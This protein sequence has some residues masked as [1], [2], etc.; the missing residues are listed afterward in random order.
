[1][2]LGRKI[3]A[4]LMT[5]IFVILTVLTVCQFMVPRREP[6]LTTI[7]RPKNV[8]TN[9]IIIDNEAIALANNPAMISIYCD[10]VI[11]SINNQRAVQG[12][13]NFIKSIDLCAAAS[14]RATEQ[15][16]YFSHTRP[17]GSEFWTV[18]SQVCYGECLSK[19]YG[20]NEVVEA[21]MNSPTHRSVLLDTEFKTAGIGVHEVNGQ[22]FIALEVG[23]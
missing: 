16:Q 17:D 15:E 12:L 20:P 22:C 1:M 14:V 7:I 18:N 19:G 6:A 13:S 23:Y 2:N 5:S 21:W 4:I 3:V 10:S 8:E 9:Y 11:A